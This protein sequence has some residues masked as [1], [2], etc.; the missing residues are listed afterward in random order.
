MI[1]DGFKLIDM[2]K[3]S[4]SYLPTIWHGNSHPQLANPNVFVR[5]VYIFVYDPDPEV[6]AA[7]YVHVRD[8]VKMPLGTDEGLSEASKSYFSAL[9]V[10]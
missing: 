10:L 8:N 2:P 7:K 9:F 1:P 3:E 5:N 6:M 4:S